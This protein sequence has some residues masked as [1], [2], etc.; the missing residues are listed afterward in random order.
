M[1]AFR[2]EYIS[3]FL[4]VPKVES[5]FYPA[6]WYQPVT[7]NDIVRQNKSPSPIKPQ[8]ANEKEIFLE[9]FRRSVASL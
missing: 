6:T 3:F 7:I 4:M 2:N 9:F 5:Q 8:I 1:T